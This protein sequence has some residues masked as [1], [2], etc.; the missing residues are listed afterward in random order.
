VKILFFEQ[1]TNEPANLVADLY[2]FLDV[3]PAWRPPNLGSNPNPARIPRSPAKGRLYSFARW[4][5]LLRVIVQSVSH[6]RRHALLGRARRWAYKKPPLK[7][8]LRA[9]LRTHFIDDLRELQ[10]LLK[11]PLPPAW[12]EPHG[13][14]G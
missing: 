9:E 14:I 8:E 7:P 11:R 5:P 13:T 1:L 4:N 3:D 12:L 2:R 10:G 6:R